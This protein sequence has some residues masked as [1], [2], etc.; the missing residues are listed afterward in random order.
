MKMVASARLKKAE[1]SALK[2]RNFRAKIEEIALSLSMRA[3]EKEHFLLS[4]N[5]SDTIGLVVITSDRGLCGAFNTLLLKSVVKYCKEL[6]E[7]NKKYKIWVVGR[8]GATFLTKNKLN[9]A[10]SYTGIYRDLNIKFAD[11]IGNE[12]LEQYRTGEIGKIVL[13]YN[14]YKSIL[15][16]IITFKHLIPVSENLSQ[17]FENNPALKDKWTQSDVD[18]IYE[19]SGPEILND[20][21]PMYVSTEIYS[22]VLESIV[23][24]LASRMTAM[25]SATNNAEDRIKSLTIYYNRMRQAAITKEIAEIVGGASALEE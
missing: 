13:V 2:Y 4:N 8:K 14:Y 18:Y 6:E 3:D 12:M 1:Q 16:Q 11:L 10:K 22:T 7:Q 19:P 25:D 17:M 21:L 20:L 23:G 24:E 5:N 9:I 15:R